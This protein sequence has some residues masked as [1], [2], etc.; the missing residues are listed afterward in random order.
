[1]TGVAET[2]A[3]QQEQGRAR[4][5]ARSLIMLWLAGGP[6]Q[7]ETFDPHPESPIAA[8]TKAIDTSVKGIQFAEGLEQTAE[9]MQQLLVLRSVVSK[10]GDHERATYNVKT[11]YRPMTSLVHP[12]IGA[13]LCHQLPTAGTEIPRHISIL[14]AG[15]P[16]RGGY[17]GDAFDAFQIGDPRGP[18]PDMRPFVKDERLQHRLSDVGVIDQVF[19]HQR[20]PELEARRTLHE[21]T[22]TQATQMMDSEQLRA[23][24]LSE[25]P[26][27][28]LDPFGDTPFGRG[29]LAAARLI[30]V[31]VRCVEVSLSGWDSHVANHE[32]HT[33]L[34]RSLDPAFAALIRYLQRH[35]LLE[36]TLVVCGGEFGRTPQMN[37]AGG[38][39]HWPHGFSVV[40]AG[41][42]LPSGIV[43][44][45][46]DPLG[47]KLSF[48]QGTTVADVHATLLDRFGLDPTKELH[49]PI[50][51]PMKLSDGRIRFDFGFGAISSRGPYVL[52][53]TIELATPIP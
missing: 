38:R 17:L 47:G 9:V 22:I 7:L 8:E 19:A 35:S 28:E 1:M 26:R 12:S 51:R 4:G 44:G 42:G 16:P 2:L 41:G 49:T 18:L 53:W 6:S 32:L 15:W 29:C 11:G 31:G 46:T 24:D 25:L 50:G 48:D 43:V 52:P 34:K 30:E 37:P 5:P 10:E 14:S 3:W 39:D 33:K 20:L 13:V 45:E 23:F 27:S 21:R 36:E 40:L